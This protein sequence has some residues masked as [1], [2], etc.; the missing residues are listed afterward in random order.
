[1][2]KKGH[3]KTSGMNK[4][5]WK[6]YKEFL[7]EYLD[8]QQQVGFKT[9]KWNRSIKA[10]TSFVTIMTYSMSWMI[11]IMNLWHTTNSKRKQQNTTHLAY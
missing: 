8:R 5:R 9:I 1:M 3:L 4:W 6:I 2:K 11:V 10:A 7:Q